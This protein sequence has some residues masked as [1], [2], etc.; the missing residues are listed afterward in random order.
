MAWSSRIR[1]VLGAALLGAAPL[2]SAQQADLRLQAT[3]SG[4]VVTQTRTVNVAFTATNLGP[5]AATGVAANSLAVFPFDGTQLAYSIDP[6]CAVTSSGPV[7]AQILS[8]QIGTLVAGAQ[9]QCTFTL[10]ALPTTVQQSEQ[11]GLRVS[12]TEPDPVSSNNTAGRLLAISPIDVVSDIGIELA[13][14]PAQ[15]IIPRDGSG[16]LFVTIRNLGPETAQVIQAISDPYP[17]PFFGPYPFELFLVPEDPCTSRLEVELTSSQALVGPAGFTL[18]AGASVTCVLGIDVPDNV[19][20]VSYTLVFRSALTFFGALDPNPANDLGRIELQ[21][22]PPPV[23]V[24]ASN[25]FGLAVLILTLLVSAS[26]FG[27]KA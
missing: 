9:R 3:F 18:P 10:R 12:G 27:R 19:S 2:C 17:S 5:D 16:R 15:G 24:R 1:V 23:P 22:S 13:V 11:F 21:L 6:G 7:N 14:Q 8:W 26:M 20:I 25:P 4:E